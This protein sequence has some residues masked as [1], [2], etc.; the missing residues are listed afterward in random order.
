MNPSFWLSPFSQG[1]VGGGSSSAKTLH[2]IENRFRPRTGL[3]EASYK[4][5]PRS[6]LTEASYKED[7]RTGLAEASYKDAEFRG[8]RPRLQEPC[9]PPIDLISPTGRD[10]AR[11]LQ[12]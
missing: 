5:D 11:L 1:G 6:G 8:Q 3:T 10:P 12:W 4:E 9:N 2:S 7:P